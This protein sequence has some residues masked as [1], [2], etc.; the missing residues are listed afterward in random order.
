MKS[1]K[2]IDLK[3]QLIGLFEK[4]EV[5]AFFDFELAVDPGASVQ[6]LCKISEP[7]AGTS[8]SNYLS[9]LFIIDAIDD[10]IEA[11]VDLY[12]KGILWHE[13]K[14]R[15]SGIDMVVPMPHVS[16]GTRHYLKEVEL[17][18][19]RKTQ[20]T[21]SFVSGDLYPAIVKTLGCRGGEPVFWNDLPREKKQF[22]LTELPQGTDRSLIETIIDYFKGK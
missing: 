15:M 5:L 20:I 18:L 10:A 3:Q 7:K 14:D 9:L 16:Y 11:K 2:I 13:F 1:E 4:E 21:P 19:G 17:Y 6:G 12:M 8:K 22:E